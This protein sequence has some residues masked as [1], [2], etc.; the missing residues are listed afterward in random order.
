MSKK[1]KIQPHPFPADNFTREE[2]RAAIKAVKEITVNEQYGGAS[3]LPAIKEKDPHT[4][5]EKVLER[6]IIELNDRI[7]TQYKVIDKLVRDVKRLKDQI[8]E[9]AGRIPR[10]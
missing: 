8:S 7:T 9:L 10:G 6:Q 4:E 2:I 3:E 1:I 5:K